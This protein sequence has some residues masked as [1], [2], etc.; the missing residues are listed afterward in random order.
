MKEKKLA[1]NREGDGYLD[2]E[3]V[4]S[5][6]ECTGLI[7]TPPITEAEAESYAQLYTVPKPQRERPQKSTAKTTESKK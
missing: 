4:V 5:G 2:P 6:T 7:P 1:Q 3:D